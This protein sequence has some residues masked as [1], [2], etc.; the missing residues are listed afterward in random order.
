LGS[1]LISLGMALIDPADMAPAFACLAEAEAILRAQN[2]QRFL[3]TCLGIQAFCHGRAGD[4]ANAERLTREA[5]GV[6]ER[7]GCRRVSTEAR[8]Y[9][10]SLIYEAGRVEEAI[11]QARVQLERCRDSAQPVAELYVSF[12]LMAYLLH[13]NQRDAALELL[14]GV[15]SCYTGPHAYMIQVARHAGLLAAEF[16]RLETAA[17]LAGY[18]NAYERELGLFADEALDKVSRER[19][20]ALLA[21]TPPVETPKWAETAVLELLQGLCA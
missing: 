9:L 10:V 16:G 7:I 6:A 8:N 19:T 17:R 11:A 3:A 18:A 15:L 5:L 13:N 14:P 2:H 12:R 1:A 20:A 4:I 21:G